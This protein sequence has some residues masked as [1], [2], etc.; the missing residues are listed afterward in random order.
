MNRVKPSD[1]LDL[2][3][4][5][6]SLPALGHASVGLGTHDTTSPVAGSIL[7]VGLEVAVVDSGDELGELSLV[8]GADLGKGEDG[9]GLLV[10]N[11][12]ETGLALDDN[13]GDTHLAAEG[14]EEDNEL[15][16]VDVVGDQ[17]E[18][19]L[20]VLDEA[21]NVVETELGGVGLL[22]DIL[23]LLALGDGGSLLGQTL[24]LLDLG[25]R[26]VLV[27]ELESLGGDYNVLAMMRLHIP[28]MCMLTVA[29]SNVLEL[30]NRRGDLQAEVED[31]L[32]A[33]KTDVRGPP[34]HA[35]EVALGLD[36]LADAIVLGALLDERVLLSVRACENDREVRFSTYLSG[37]LG[38]SLSLGEGGGGGL[39][40]L[41]RHFEL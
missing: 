27:E 5:L 13:V 15:D 25:L 10:N 17:D 7:V 21:D 2:D 35:A 23:L 3:S 32:L 14:G 6:D 12:T 28:C 33:L 20:L 9:S 37:L 1:H 22:G 36:V 29:V 11:G 41:R 30:G 19:G 39:L 40:S 16:G 34:D 38:A 31:L 24:L 18:R 26:A 4:R 8:L